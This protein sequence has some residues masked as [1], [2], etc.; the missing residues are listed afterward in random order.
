METLVALK[1]RLTHWQSSESARS[2]LAMSEKILKNQQLVAD[3]SISSGRALCWCRAS[4]ALV[5]EGTE[6][7]ERA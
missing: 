6:H 5:P 7:R 4:L 2:G 1:G 3:S